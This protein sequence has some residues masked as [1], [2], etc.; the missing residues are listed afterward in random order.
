MVIGLLF[1]AVAALCGV[2]VT[3]VCRAPLSLAPMVGLAA[4][5]V[6][7][8]W[9]A[10]LGL[11]PLIA[12]GAVVLL[13]LGGLVTIRAALASILLRDRVAT[14]ILVVSVAI[15]AIL[16]GAALANLDAPVSTHDGAFH[17][18][19]VENLRHGVAVQG[20]YPM[21][22]HA[23]V[24]AVLGLTPW[25]D[26][27][28]G[29]ADAAQALAMLAPLAIFGLGLAIGLGPRLASLGGLV[30]ALTYIYPYDDHLWGG[31]P[32]AMSILLLL[33]LWA[34][35]ARWI[36]EPRPG[37]A[38]L[39]GLL[40]GA[41]VLTHGTE[42]Y[43]AVI[44]L[45]VIA[46]LNLRRMQLRPLAGHVALAAAAAV[47]CDA[48]YLT[49]LVGWA[50]G[51]GAT[52][53]A[54][55]TLDGTVQGNGGA[56]GSDPLEFVLGITGAASLI[57]LPVR[58][59]LIVIGARQR[60]L[61][62]A[63]AG[64]LAFGALLFVVSFIDVQPVC[65][66]Y[67][68]TFPWLVHHRPPQMVVLFTSLLVGGGVFAVVRWF[69]RLRA[70]FVGRPATWR[71]LTIVS[72]ALLLFMAE[73][74]AVS[75]F[76]TLDQVISNQNVYSADDRAAMS[77]LSQHATPGEMVINDMA[78][79]AGI[80]APYKA[81]LAILLPRSA[82]GQIE[83][84]RWPILSHLVDLSQSSSIAATA[85]A[86]HADYVYQGSRLVPDE[87][88]QLP[89]RATLERTPGLHEVFSSGDAAVF[90]VELACG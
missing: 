67:V 40:A 46:M 78:T 47:I 25:L 14:A 19:T 6:L 26:T 83:S 8:S 87:K 68:L 50:A 70:R 63:L 76:K 82:S 27:A 21:G 56:T 18:E 10:R 88:S 60:Q 7:T 15:P 90:R 57:D 28:R 3:R 12:T 85:C 13:A 72:A 65:S 53:V 39:G 31:W 9:S 79:D 51:G 81:G 41:I 11:P 35:A 33:G 23:S 1:A 36:A 45:A 22:F 34:V 5:A 37:L 84:D 69:G 4:M 58:A 86:L 77:W 62:L 71:R 29:T 32:L 80:W 43:S 49:S 42:V 74:S 55:G 64:F 2:G 44:G 52:V 16:L 89:D 59:A 54:A 75:I 20:W 38:A 61:R 24:A 17:V 48:P 73:G 66:L 30:Q